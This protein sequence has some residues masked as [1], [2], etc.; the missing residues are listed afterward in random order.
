MLYTYSWA[1]TITGLLESFSLIYYDQE[2]DYSEQNL[3][4]CVGIGV[5]DGGFP[6]LGL[7]YF[8]NKGLM[9]TSDYGNYTANVCILNFKIAF[10]YIIN[11][12]Y[13]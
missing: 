6:D 12:N 2:V 9:Y 1:F 8:L 4:D 11:N 7:S 13:I 3:V 5:C 10:C